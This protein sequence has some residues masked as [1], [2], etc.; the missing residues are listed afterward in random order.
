[1]IDHDVYIESV[2]FGLYRNW[3]LEP[4]LKVGGIIILADEVPGSLLSL[5]NEVNQRVKVHINE[6]IYAGLDE[7]KKFVSKYDDSELLTI[8]ELEYYLGYRF[9]LGT[10]NGIKEA[11]GSEGVWFL[12]NSIKIEEHRI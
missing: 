7:I 6:K 10:K 3:N 1:M 2:F 12:N 9:T 8:K 11:C 4:C 5:F